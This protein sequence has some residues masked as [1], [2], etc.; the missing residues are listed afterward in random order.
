MSAPPTLGQ[1]VEILERRYEPRW[2]ESWDAVGLTCGDPDNPVE[3]VV[4]AVDPAAATVEETIDVGAE[5][6][7]THHPLFLRPVH[8]VAATTPKGRL[9][10]RLVSNGAGL[11]TAH[12]NA[13]AADPG[14]SDA[15]AETLGLTDLRPL[16][17]QPADPLDKLVV[18]VPDSDAERLLD[19]LAAAG[20]GTIG[21]YERCAWTTTGVGTFRPLSGASP[22]IG[23]VGAIEVVPEMRIEMVLPRSRR[24]DVVRALL[25][26]HPYEE[27]AYDVYELAT[28]PGSRGIGRI[29][30]LDNPE[31]LSR[32]VQR[33]AAALPPSAAGVRA[34]G[35]PERTIRTVAVCGGAGDSLLAAVR[36]AGV[37]AYLTADLRHH[38]ASESG[39]DGGPALVDVSHW[40]SEWPWLRQAQAALI[41][42]LTKLGTTVETRVSTTRTDPW[43]LHGRSEG[44]TP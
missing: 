22:T 5:L 39:E 16:D 31:P 27:P 2:A 36:A 12:T 41:D 7:V 25:D 6:L 4:F 10:H 29:G 20:A 21:A 17:P 37:D 38:P 3:R 9:I 8:S 43:T 32:F 40:A 15:L 28:H 44:S 33:A 1:I 14:V 30:T 34:S 13:D 19:A 18:F 35:D 42:G 23:S 26:T 11:F 24:I